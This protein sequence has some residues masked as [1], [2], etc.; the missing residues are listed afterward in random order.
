ME[1]E[2]VFR[3][4]AKHLSSASMYCWFPLS[5]KCI[6]E[7]LKIS[8]YKCLKCLH[9]LREQGL[10]KVARYRHYDDYSEEY[11][12]V[13]GWEITD[14]GKQTDMYIEE[15]EKNDKIIEEIFQVGC[16]VTKNEQRKGERE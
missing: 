11:W 15:K 6:S 7:T 4:L 14:K 2:K 13:C 1:N 8:R 12:L 10:V 9:E 3:L 5:A 16:G